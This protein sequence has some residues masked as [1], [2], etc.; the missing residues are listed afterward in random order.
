MQMKIRLARASILLALSLLAWNCHAAEDQN[1]S[2]DVSSK[3]NTY[4]KRKP[5]DLALC[6]AKAFPGDPQLTIAVSAHVDAGSDSDKFKSYTG[7][8]AV[9]DRSTVIASYEDEYE[10]DDGFGLGDLVIDTAPYILASNTRA[11]GVRLFNS[12]PPHCN[13]ASQN[14]SLT[15]YIHEPA[16]LRPILSIDTE[17]WRNIEGVCSSARTVINKY[18]K[19]YLSISKSSTNKFNDIIV[20]AVSHYEIA[21]EDGKTTIVNVKPYVEI[22]KFNGKDYGS[23]S[24]GFEAWFNA[25]QLHDHAMSSDAH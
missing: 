19:L 22:L 9:L 6:H 8:V 18:A 12:P 16:K 1:C 7:H 23:L 15:L 14:N 24:S 3:L 5:E 10:E 20:T 17:Y 13:D 25:D 4:F 2:A 21:G 11:F